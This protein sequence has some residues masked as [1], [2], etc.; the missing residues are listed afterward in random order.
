MA[1]QPPSYL[2]PRGKGEQQK[3]SGGGGAFLSHRPALQ[4]DPSRP[5]V[6]CPGLPSWRGYSYGD[7]AGTWTA[8]S[9]LAAKPRSAPRPA[10]PQH[11][12]DYASSLQEGAGAEGS[13]QEVQGGASVQAAGG[14][15]FREPDLE[16]ECC[17]G[18]ACKTGMRQ[19]L[20]LT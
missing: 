10:P 11:D 17:P 4:K 18:E 20:P 14:E 12:L 6:A 3:E 8:Q 19:A 9:H 16:H 7:L 15:A 2:G 13:L 5:R 1:C